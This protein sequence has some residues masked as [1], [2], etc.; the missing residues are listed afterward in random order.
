VTVGNMAR[1]GDTAAFGVDE[2]LP[3]E[4]ARRR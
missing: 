2:Y 1:E 3:T 4:L